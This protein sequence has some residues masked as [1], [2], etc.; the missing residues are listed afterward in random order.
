MGDPP[1]DSPGGLLI[2][3]I[4]GKSRPAGEE[5]LPQFEEAHRANGE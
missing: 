4:A 5:K 1:P 2:A 3:I